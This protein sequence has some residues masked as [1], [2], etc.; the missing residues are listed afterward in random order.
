LLFCGSWFT[1]LIGKTLW[2]AVTDGLLSFWILF[3]TGLMI[4]ITSLSKALEARAQ[5]NK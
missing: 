5:K 1:P 2:H 3:A 4:A